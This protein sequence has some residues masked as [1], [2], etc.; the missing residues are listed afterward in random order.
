MSSMDSSSLARRL[1][2][3]VGLLYLLKETPKAMV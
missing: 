1:I 3:W 2:Y